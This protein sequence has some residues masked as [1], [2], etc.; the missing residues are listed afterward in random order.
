MRRLVRIGFTD[1]GVRRDLDDE[2]AFH[3]GSRADELIADGLTPAAA[4]EQAEREYGDLRASYHELYTV[5]RRRLDRGRKEE[6]MT[7]LLEDLR[8]AARGLARRPGLTAVVV[9][10]LTIGIAANAIMFGVVDQLLVRPPA[11]VSNPSEVHRIY[12][13]STNDGERSAASRTTFR[14]VTA[15]RDH[16]PEFAGVAGFFATTATIGRGADAQEIDLEMVS[17]NYFDLLGVKLA[18]GRAFRAEEDAPPNGVPVA[19]VSDAFWRARL[20]GRRDVIG[21]HIEINT[22]SFTIVGVAPADFTSLDH[23]RVD[24]WVP[25]A[26]VASEV[27]GD[28]WYRAPNSWW[29]QAIARIERDSAV[30]RAAAV[31]T[32]VYRQE[33]FSWDNPKTDSTVGVVL[34]SIVGA[35]TPNGITAEGRIALWLMGVAFVVLLIACANAAN[36]LIARMLQRRREIAVRLALG[37]SRG[38]LAR[39]LLTESALLAAIAACSAIIVSIWG[40]RLVQHVLLPNIAWSHGILD[41]RVLLFTLIATIVCIFLAGCAPAVQATRTSVSAALHGS[42]RQIAGGRGRLRTMLLVAQAALSVLLLIGAGLFVKSLRNVVGRDI[43]VAVDHVALVTMNLRRAGFTPQ[44]ID[45]TFAEGARRIRAIPGVASTSL[46]AVTVPLR[47]A[48]AVSIKLPAGTPRPKMGGGG[49]YYGVV[50]NDFFATMGTRLIAGRLFQDDELRS[51]SRVMLVNEL[52]AKAYWPGRNPIGE[53]VELGSDNICTRI[54]GVVQNVML[55]NMVKDDRAMLYL[56]PT[57]P[58]FGIGEHP[59]AVLVR[60]SGDPA[61]VVSAVRARL[62]GMSRRMPYVQ[63]SPFA[64]LLAPQLRPWRLGATM[65]TLFGALALII[66]AVGLYSVMAYWVSQR[67]HEIGVRMA[68]GAQSDDVVRLVMRQASQPIIVG[69]AIGGVCAF[70]ASRWIADLLYETSP[71]D[72]LTYGIAAAAL[73]LSGLVASIAPA[74]RSTTVDPATAL[75]AD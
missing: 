4:R 30:E 61:D 40:A 66:A 21:S 57:H 50:G 13:Q 29:V 46:V 5:D 19:V 74:R 54:V 18:Q 71:H 63:V 16:V 38:R 25:I 35:R 10:V 22:K 44:E 56:P 64:K 60:T 49:P 9:A 2:I 23:E 36:L 58:G 67:T 28:D 34:G 68:L 75:R 42:A 53:C 14:A 20:T 32:T 27:I 43:G 51:P 12:F 55:F 7:S 62:Q 24:V 59:L 6:I 69:I 73:V 70:V 45:A 17:G 11:G 1:A 26:S 41:A 31:A 15:L 47:S 65:F 37:V 48:S 3:L 52:V 33:Y 72:P 8:Y 39:Q